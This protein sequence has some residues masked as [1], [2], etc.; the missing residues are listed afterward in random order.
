MFTQIWTE[1]SSLSSS[2]INPKA[3]CKINWQHMKLVLGILDCRTLSKHQWKLTHSLYTGEVQQ[4]RKMR[5]NHRKKIEMRPSPVAGSF[6][7]IICFGTRIPG[8]CV[9]LCSMISYVSTPQHYQA[10]EGYPSLNS[11]ISLCTTR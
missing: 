8:T 9:N 7:P 6:H 2:H 4:C 3:Y 1:G 10:R 5:R 11:M